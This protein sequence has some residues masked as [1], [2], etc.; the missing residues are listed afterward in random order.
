MCQGMKGM[1]GNSGRA[2][3]AAQRT[4]ALCDY[5][6]DQIAQLN[7]FLEMRDIEEIVDVQKLVRVSGVKVRSRL[8][9]AYN[10]RPEVMQCLGS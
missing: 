2:I 5:H 1:K 6:K 10:P 8:G 7:V 9:A 3:E 4:V